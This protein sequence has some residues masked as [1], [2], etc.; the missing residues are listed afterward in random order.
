MLFFDA[1]IYDSFS[2]IVNVI[3]KANRDITLIC[4]N[5]LYAETAEANES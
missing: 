2:L 1:Q 3:Q 5:Y 4:S